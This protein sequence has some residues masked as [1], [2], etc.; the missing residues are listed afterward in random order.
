MLAII[1]VIFTD[2]TITT[3]KLK[4]LFE[5]LVDPKKIDVLGDRL[6]L[7]QSERDNILKNYHSPS[8]RKD[9]YLDLYVHHHPCPHWSNIA[10]LLS[11]CGL[12][13]QARFVENTYVKGTLW[14]YDEFHNM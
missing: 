5:S 2:L 6:G 10:G 13:Q 1:F 9:A 7:S 12:P 8:Q 11:Y 14:L 3:D 4:E